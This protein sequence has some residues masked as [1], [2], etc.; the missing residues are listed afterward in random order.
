[1]SEVSVNIKEDSHL[2]EIMVIDLTV[3]YAT[4]WHSGATNATRIDMHLKLDEAKALYE[5]LQEVFKVQT[6]GQ[7]G[8]K[9]L[10]QAKTSTP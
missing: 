7:G 2:N 10:S 3:P 8:N 1:M 4:I 6:Q 5:A 9:S